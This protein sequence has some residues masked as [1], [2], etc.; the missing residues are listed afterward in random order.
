MSPQPFTIFDAVAAPFD[1]PSVDTD[2]IIPVRFIRTPRADG[3]ET[4]LF[5][6]LRFHPDGSER[7]QFVLNRPGHRDTG[8]LV[9]STDFGTGSSR[10]QAV[11]A[12][13]DYGIRCV[14]AA[15]FGDIFSNNAVNHGLL[16]IRETPAELAAVRMQLEQSP[17]TRIRVDLAAQ[18]WQA[19]GRGVRPFDI[20]PARKQRLLSGLDEIGLTQRFGEE[21]Q[22]FE[23]GY[24]SRRSWLF[25]HGK[26]TA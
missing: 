4:M 10:E 26:P 1:H 8:I 25:G 21:I 3:Y 18:T 23:T 7:T 11:W 22:R 17:G 19:E 2:Q 13:I 6:D 24:R 5:R 15:S 12:L 9:A 14:I 16:L 20:E